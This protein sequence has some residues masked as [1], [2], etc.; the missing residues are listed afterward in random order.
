MNDHYRMSSTCVLLKMM[1][2]S[3]DSVCPPKIRAEGFA[4]KI[5]HKQWAGKKK[6]LRSENLPPP[7]LPHH[8]SKKV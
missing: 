2:K 7:P 5:L 6:F 1:E 3:R 8:F 4:E